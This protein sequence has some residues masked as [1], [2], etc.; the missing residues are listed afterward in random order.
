MYV[1]NIIDVAAAEVLIRGCCSTLNHTKH[2]L[3]SPWPPPLS[4]SNE[5]RAEFLSP[6]QKNGQVTSRVL[7]C[8]TKGCN[9]RGV[10][11]SSRKAKAKTK[12]KE[13]RRHQISMSILHSNEEEDSIENRKNQ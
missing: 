7:F 3:A 2:H 1:F 12:A 9:Q 10:P 8:N 13:A 6:V 4:I 5:F 11:W